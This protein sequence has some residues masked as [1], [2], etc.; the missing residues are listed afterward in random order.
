MGFIDAHTSTLCGRD[1]YYIQ[2]RF[3]TPPA[4]TLS[5]WLG[6]PSK[7]A[8]PPGS[9][10]TENYLNLF[11][12]VIGLCNAPR[13]IFGLFNVVK[14]VAGLC[15]DAKGVAGLCSDAKGVAGLCSDARGVAGL[16]SDARGVAGLC[17]DVRG[18]AG[19]CSDAR[20]VA[21]LCS[22]A[23]GVAGLC[24]VGRGVVGLCSVS[25]GIAGLFRGLSVVPLSPNHLDLSVHT[26]ED[27]SWTCR[28]RLLFRCRPFDISWSAAWFS[29]R[30]VSRYGQCGRV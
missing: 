6:D 19:L 22:D 28:D 2:K 16:C 11:R 26:R 4:R 20:G 29:E 9:L 8:S 1:F 15:S 18:V 27:K 7:G 12:V 23:T 10:C 5:R 13:G 14:G 3:Q 21:G 17:S 25:G 30:T 24:S